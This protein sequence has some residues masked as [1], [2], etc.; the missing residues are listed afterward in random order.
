MH[1]QAVALLKG[2]VLLQVAG[3]D[4]AAGH[5]E[6]ALAQV[7]AGERG[8]VDGVV[9]LDCKVAC[10][11]GHVENVGRMRGCHQL[12]SHLAPPLVD[13]HGHGAVHE[14]VGWCDVVE[15]CL[16][17]LGLALFFAIGLDVLYLVV[18]AS[19]SVVKKYKT[20][21]PAAIGPRA[22]RGKLR[23]GE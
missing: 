21:Q 13:A 1:V 7:D 18:H 15:H 10:A 5:V 11:C 9:E 20:A 14:V 23:N 17:L 22:C 4:L 16:H 3:L 19:M 6:H 12:A 2:D 8:G